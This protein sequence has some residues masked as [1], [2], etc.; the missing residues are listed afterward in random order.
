MAFSAG[1][2]LA[3]IFAVNVAAA[4]AIL[5]LSAVLY[6]II[7]K[8]SDAPMLLIFA[9]LGMLLYSYQNTYSGPNSLKNYPE[10]APVTGVK[11][12]VVTDPETNDERSYFYADVI[13]LYSKTGETS[14]ISGRIR[15]TLEKSLGFK[16]QYGDVLF[17]KGRLREPLPPL[18]PGEFDYRKY[19]AYRQVYFTMNAKD[20]ACDKTGT[21][22]RNWFYYW[23]YRSKVKLLGIIYGSLPD[24]EARILEGLLLGNQRVIP[25][26]VYDEFKITGTVH[27][28]AVSGMNVGLI[29]LF[30]FF[31]LKM[32]R[33]KRKIGALIT[34]VLITA[35]AVMTGAGASIVRA[36]L[37]GYIVLIAIMIER[38]TDIMNSL[39]VAAFLILLFNPSDLFDAGFQLSFLATAG[40]VYYCEW[41]MKLFPKVP[42]VISATA[43][44]TIAAQVFLTPVMVNT[45]HQLSLI[46]ILAN[47]VVVP[48]TGTISMIG[49][50]MWVAGIFGMWA[51]KIFGA[52]IW[53]LINFMMFFVH[54]L[55]KVPYAAIS[56]KSLPALYTVMYYLA[57]IS[58]PHNDIDIKFK[59]I[60]AK[61]AILA[62]VCVWSVLHVTVAPPSALYIPACRGISTAL[63][64]TKDNKKIIIIGRD[65]FRSKAAA[66]SSLVPILRYMGINNIDALIAYSLT[67]QENADALLRSFR[68]KKVY[69]DRESAGLFRD[70]VAVNTEFYFKEGGETFINLSPD[71]ADI[72]QG[73][74]EMIIAETISPDISKRQG[75]II[76]PFEYDDKQAC[77]LGAANTVI[78]NSLNSGLYRKKKSPDCPG[79]TDVGEKGMFYRGI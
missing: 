61:Y 48:V 23:S 59:K 27:I 77:G 15:V 13:S 41:V 56:V 58:L 46:S 40:L 7:G 14:G 47:L 44:S 30:V 29:A 22:I 49:F 4:I 1:I 54:L 62:V 71:R 57:F 73:Q 28:L 60:S 74:N 67:Q 64:R 72:T 43:A 24:S 53:V 34:M 18:N 79:I 50:S 16:P 66:R 68:I 51:A 65:N 33:I 8:K 55:A 35:F 21:D 12:V 26:S 42:D 19:L 70:P 76:Y 9:A 2:A 39:A 11:A 75:T 5:A 78:I 37:M 63:I 69:A 31:L 52:S 6:F 20:S 17:I 32:L 45:F 3:D 25:D 10:I 36:T 38:D